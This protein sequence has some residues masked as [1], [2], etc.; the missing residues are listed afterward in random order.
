MKVS[1]VA[2]GFQE[3]YVI[4]LLNSLADTDVSIDFIGADIYDKNEINPNVSF[5][6]L[7]G[8]HNEHVSLLNK[9]IRVFKYYLQLILYFIRTDSKVIHVQWFRF[10]FFEGVIISFIGRICN[11]KIFYTAHD[12]LPHDKDNRYNRILFWFIYRI[13]NVLIV[14]TEFIK[15]RISNE[16]G[17]SNTKIFVIKH[18]V[19]IRKKD[20]SISRL[21]AKIKY[22]ISPNEFSILFFGNIVKYKGL[23]ILLEAFKLLQNCG[24]FKLLIAGKVNPDYEVEMQRLRKE[25]DSNH[26]IYL[27]DYIPDNDIEFI[28]K[29]SD[30]TVLPYLEASQSGVMFM[31]Y[32]YGRPVIA[33]NLGGFKFDII[34]GKTGFIFE[35]GCVNDLVNCVLKTRDLVINNDEDVSREIIEIAESTYSWLEIAK[36]LV[37]VYK[38]NSYI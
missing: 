25:H 23:N 12:V 7:R 20:D 27:L 32:A 3:Q 36:V 4:N 26:I 21:N 2:N 1:I 31:S 19:Y 11:K 24:N 15:E 13:Q 6:N 16:F 9:V 8:S 10:P 30:V 18:G 14:H 35:V 22:C 17:I 28:F 29:A 5:V 37:M 34:E 38:L 33:P